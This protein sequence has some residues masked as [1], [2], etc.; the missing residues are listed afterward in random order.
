MKKRFFTAALAAVV[1]LSGTAALGSLSVNAEEIS[2]GD[3]IAIGIENYNGLEYV[4]CGDGNIKI[5]GYTGKDE[6]VEIPAEIEGRKVTSVGMNAF[7]NCVTKVKGFDLKEVVIPETVTE[8]GEHAF[9]SCMWLEK[10]NIPSGVTEIKDGTFAQCSKLKEVVL[11]YDTEKIGES[12]FYLCSGLEK[13]SLPFNKLEKIGSTAFYGCKNLKG[14]IVPDT[15]KEYGSWVTVGCDS[16]ETF[17]VPRCM[18]EE[19]FFD[20]F[21]QSNEIHLDKIKTLY[22]YDNIRNIPDYK[23]GYTYNEYT[24]VNDF[25]HDFTLFCY[26]GSPADEYAEKFG[27]KCIYMTYPENLPPLDEIITSDENSES[28]SDDTDSST[29]P[30]LKGD[31]NGDKQLSSGDALDCLK[32]IVGIS[33]FDENQK[34]IADVNGDGIINTLDALQILKVV[35]G[36]IDR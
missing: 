36:L 28:S 9:D 30:L 22:V 2:Q 12:A 35:V 4:V 16:L 5:T 29:P 19:Q 20:V 18:T 10:I 31:L 3:V 21:Y 26:K 27:V 8:I 14:L 25:N 13:V 7:E 15:V 23:F 11:P 34:E 6:K 1:A 17:A 32:Y 33:D 24:C